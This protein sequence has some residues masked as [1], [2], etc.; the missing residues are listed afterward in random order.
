MSVDNSGLVE[1]TVPCTIDPRVRSQQRPSDLHVRIAIALEHWQSSGGS[2]WSYGR[3]LRLCSKTPDMRLRVAHT[4][5]NVLY[6]SLVDRGRGHLPLCELRR[7]LQGTRSEV[8]STSK[9]DKRLDEVLADMARRYADKLDSSQMASR[10]NLSRSRFQHLFRQYTGMSFTAALTDI[11]LAAAAR[12]LRESHLRISEICYGVGFEN[13]SLFDRR[14]HARFGVSPS[15]F[16][17]LKE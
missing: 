13:T 8:Q 16:R 4:A 9:G 17:R 11:R 12:L 5:V 7:A 3:I 14:F 1:L 2:F 6:E 10:C 15:G